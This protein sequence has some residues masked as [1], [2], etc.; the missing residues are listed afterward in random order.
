MTYVFDSSILV[1][2]L[3]E[4][5][6]HHERALPW[7]DRMAGGEVTVVLAAHTLAEAYCGITR[8]PVSPRVT[9]GMAWQLIRDNIAKA[10]IVPLTEA[11]YRRTIEHITGLGL[12]GGIIYDALV[13]RVAEK[14]NADHLVTF[15]ADHF[16]RVWPEGRG[17]II[18]P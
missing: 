17:R 3:V 4:F 9:P 10:R 11:D 7:T 16:Y 2:G 13:A 1:A 12:A 5:H 18:A 14:T 8:L 6:P 15:N